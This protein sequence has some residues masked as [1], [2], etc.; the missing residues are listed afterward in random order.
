VADAQIV[1]QAQETPAGKGRPAMSRGDRTIARFLRRAGGAST[2][3]RLGP[4]RPRL[5]RLLEDA[6][7][8]AGMETP[9]LLSARGRRGKPN[10]AAISIFGHR[11]VIVDRLI[12]E[13]MSDRQLGAVLAHEMAHL[14]RRHHLRHLPDM[15]AQTA[16][17]ITG[18]ALGAG[19][20]G[21]FVLAVA[22]F[23]PFGEAVHAAYTLWKVS[24]GVTGAALATR[25]VSRARSRAFESESDMDAARATADPMALASALLVLQNANPSKAGVERQAKGQVQALD[26]AQPGWKSRV[27][28]AMNTGHLDHPSIHDR[29][30]SLVDVARERGQLPADTI[31][32]PDAL[33]A[34]SD[35]VFGLV[36]SVDAVSTSK[37]A[38]RFHLRRTAVASKDRG[39]AGQI[40]SIVPPIEPGQP[41]IVEVGLNRPLSTQALDF[42]SRAL[43][44]AAKGDTGVPDAFIIARRGVSQREGAEVG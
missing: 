44:G 30:R 32:D 20:S 37:K 6:A 15:A 22:G 24:L 28:H 17:G 1:E 8:T 14:Q 38:H 40:L 10:A 5:Q 19:I 3:D 9:T 26:M 18:K 23:I 11:F 36:D 42:L 43:G 35:A 13:R 27:A 33:A 4:Q 16:L 25:E 12:A 2:R 7:A 21:A 34:I 39:P 29:I 31:D 41:A